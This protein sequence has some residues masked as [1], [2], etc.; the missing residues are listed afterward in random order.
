MFAP[1]QPRRN[2]L[3]AMTMT[4]LL[5]VRSQSIKTALLIAN[6][7]MKLSVVVVLWTTT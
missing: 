1:G 7:G 5:L 3:N 4:N 2:A 6:F